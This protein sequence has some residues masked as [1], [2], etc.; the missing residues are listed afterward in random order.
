MRTHLHPLRA[1]RAAGPVVAVLVLGSACGADSGAADAG[2]A[3][4]SDETYQRVLEQGVDPALVYTVR[5]P[6]FELAEQSAGVLGDSDYGAT[7]L[8]SEPP[9]TAEVSLEV[10]VGEY[11]EARCERDPLRGPTGADP[12]PVES[13]EPEANGWYRTGGDRHEYVAARPGHHVALGGPAEAVDREALTEAALGA[14]PQE[15][16]GA[17]PNQPT[18]PSSPVTRGDLPSTGDGAP[19]DPQ[20]TDRPGG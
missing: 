16:G 15:G 14:R 20:G 9:Y 1:A 2:A 19:V 11:D 13:C 4:L 7:Y 3:P 12:V 8:P 5:L 17:S 10:R 18:G 6:G